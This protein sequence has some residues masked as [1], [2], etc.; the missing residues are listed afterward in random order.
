[1]NFSS[2]E[3]LFKK[4]N[5][6]GNGGYMYLT[7]S[8]GSII[9]HPRQKLIDG[10]AEKENNTVNAA[11]EDGSHKENFEGER[12]I[13]TVKTVGY[14]GWKIIS[15]TPYSVYSLNFAQI[16]YFVIVIISFFIVFSSFL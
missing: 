7:D 16:R 14:T 15:V 2:I 3:Q 10:L 11:Y 1:M 5:T 8:K 6:M 9:Y 12:R 4:S 13:V